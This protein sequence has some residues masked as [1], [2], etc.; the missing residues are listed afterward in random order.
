MAVLQIRQ[1]EKSDIDEI[2]TVWERSRWDSQPWLERRMGYSREQNEQHFRFVVAREN[3]VWVAHKRGTL[4]G[5][6]AIRKAHINHLYVDPLHQGV[7][8]GTAL[9]RKA[10][11]L[12]PDKLTLFTHVR[13][14]HARSFYRSRGF[15][16]V[17]FG[18]SPEPELEPDVSYEWTPATWR[19]VN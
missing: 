13:N 17:K 15:R 1:L 7:G 2:V 5:F 3:D 9:L 16:A 11:E 8:V 4:V 19:E 18:I 10:R 14:Q 6:L 12:S